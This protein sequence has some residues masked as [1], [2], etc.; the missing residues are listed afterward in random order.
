MID[1][2]TYLDE[3]L[4]SGEEAGSKAMSDRIVK[5]ALKTLEQMCT[6]K[7]VSPWDETGQYGTVDVD[8]G[9]Y[10]IKMTSKTMFDYCEFRVDFKG[11]HT[12]PLPIKYIGPAEEAQGSQCVVFSAWGGRDL[13]GLF[14]NDAT[15]DLVG[16]DKPGEIYFSHC[17]QLQS[18]KGLPK[19]SFIQ[20]FHIYNCS[21]VSDL[22]DM[23]E[24]VIDLSLNFSP[25]IT[26]DI[27]KTIP[28]KVLKQVKK[29]DIYSC[30]V[31]ENETEE[32]RKLMPKLK[33]CYIVEL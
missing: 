12:L 6:M 27:L 28:S 8:D 14:T 32:V 1:I 18:F 19:N 10:T 15:I 2:K 33:S 22:S 20:E 25:Q 11:K 26:L 31:K 16:G 9:G 30:G 21:N 24:T 23:P 4:F 29:L 3:S 5:T 7:D 17:D 13:K